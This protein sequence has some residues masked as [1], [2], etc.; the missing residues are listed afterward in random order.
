MN[1]TMK[2]LALLIVMLLA[3]SG[4]QLVKVDEEKDKQQVV[5]EYK[6]GQILKAEALEKYNE[7][8]SIYTSYG[9]ASALNDAEFSTNLKRDTLDY[10]VTD[11]IKTEKAKEFGVDT[12]DQ[13]TVD[14]LVK[15]SDEQYE[16]MVQ[17]YLPMLKTEDQTDEEARASTVAYLEQNAGLSKSNMRNE[18]LLSYKAEQMFNYVT[19]DVELSED[20]LKAYYD[21]AVAADQLAY[22]EDPGVVEEVLGGDTV[23][24]WMP[25]GYRTVKHILIA[26][27]DEMND[28]MVALESKLSDINLEIQERTQVTDELPDDGEGDSPDEAV[29]GDVPAEVADG[30]VGS[31]EFDAG[32]A[33][34]AAADLVAEVPVEDEQP[35]DELQIPDQYNTEEEPVSATTDEPLDTV[36]E[37]EEDL[38]V[39]DLEQLNKRL[40]EVTVEITN[41]EAEMKA[42]IE[43]EVAEVQAK[44][45]AGEDFDALIEEYGDDQ[46]M[47]VEPTKTTGYYVSDT[48]TTYE[49]NFKEASMA[50][51]NV[52]D[53]SE[54][55]YTE[56]GAHI[57]RYESDVPAG[58]ADYDTVK[59]K[60]RDLALEELKTTKYEEAVESWKQEANVK[61][62]PERL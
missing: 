38:T 62:Y 48:T 57:I 58:A 13:E 16:S 60:M 18:S 10:M 1:K 53:I 52:G 26:P 24:A 39:L 61:L 29:L 54:P 22:T 8:V 27:P 43:P 46:G 50:L 14:R 21:A 51:A 49:A 31:A 12:I 5:A 35:Q 20:D 40:S 4:C 11:I 36:E 56:F 34:D 32:D 6:G 59:E 17:L 44:I 9:Y 55:I 23:V 2:L 42:A 47:Q 41:L 7:I 3:L 19:K 28:R 25:A 30:E 45:A 33:A 37:P 15:E